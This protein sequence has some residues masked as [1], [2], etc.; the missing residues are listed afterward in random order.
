MPH[1]SLKSKV[2]GGAAAVL[3]AASFA[4]P[5][6]A[7]PS[8]PLYSGGGTLAE[9]VYRDIM[10]C[11][12]SHSGTDTTFGL[13]AP[14]AICNAATPY[15]ANVEL[16]YVGVGSGNGLKAF[17]NGDPSQYIS[18]ART[19]DNPPVASTSD[20]GPFYGTGT[21]ATWAP[22]GTAT[23]YFPK[24]SFT[25]SDSPLGSAD[26]TTYNSKSNGWGSPVQFPGLVVGVTIP[27]NPSSGGFNQKGTKPSGGGNSSLVDLSTNTLCG[28]FTGGI[29]TWN[30]ANITADNN[31]VVLG[32][33]AITVIYRSDSSGTTFLTSNALINQCAGTSF[34]VPNSWQTA[35]GNTAGV[36]NTKFFI[37]VAAASLLPANFTPASGSGGVETAINTTTGSIGYVSPDFVKP[38]LAS[39]PEA[40]N[41]QTWASQGLTKV[42]KAPTASSATAIVSSSKPPSFSKASCPVG[43]GMGQSPDTICADNA[44]N[45]GVAFP[46]PTSTSA[47]PIGG[48]TFIDMYSCYHSPSD[49]TA[50]V[51]TT[52][53][54][55]GYFRWYFGSTT[56]N[57]SLVK[58][59]LTKNGFAVLPGG[60]ISGIKKLLTGDK[61]T[62]IGTPGQ[63]N[64]ACTKVTGNG[65]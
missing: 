61:T 15:N 44:L 59:S 23:N 27:F 3:F 65:A 24:V 4:A 57:A 64:T 42:W 18:G 32:T 9:K 37:N 21:G 31:G 48:F 58:N 62:D 52:A 46:K 35:A 14:P 2:L 28:I 41:L 63:A 39:G 45:W 54:S 7:T 11:Y 38:V 17:D 43:T 10:D 60:W 8:S 6:Q 53:G 47:Y 12:G 56:E 51:G 55:L 26:I 40:A 36:G 33:G 30:D 22:S 50:L 13:N 5:A 34:P 29:T 25:G 16:L 20:F 49:V 19:P 1:L